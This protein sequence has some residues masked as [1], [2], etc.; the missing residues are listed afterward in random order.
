MCLKRNFKHT[1]P[2]QRGI[3]VKWYEEEEEV[4][5]DEEEGDEEDDE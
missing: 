5:E 3:W 4:D 2:K 1:K